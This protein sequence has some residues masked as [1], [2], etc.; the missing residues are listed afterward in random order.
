[1]I[2]VK[3]LLKPEALRRLDGQDYHFC[4]GLDCEVVYFACSSG[5]HFRKT[6][7]L[8]R[9]GQKESED[10][11]PICYCFDITIADLREDLTR[12]GETRIPE[13]IAEE[14]RAGHCACE[15]KNPEGTCCLGKVREAV[16]RIRSGHQ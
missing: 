12:R 16:K 11:I 13:T 3:A 2:T 4:P 1:M 5:S 15:V 14:I 9:V 10:P 6:D 7:L 8:V